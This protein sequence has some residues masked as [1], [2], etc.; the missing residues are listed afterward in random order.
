MN[1]IRLCR[2]ANCK[3]LP[4]SYWLQN[5]LQK[6]HMGEGMLAWENCTVEACLGVGGGGGVSQQQFLLPSCNLGPH[7][8]D[9]ASRFLLDTMLVFV[10]RGVLPARFG[11]LSSAVDS[12]QCRLL[13]ARRVDLGGPVA[14]VLLADLAKER[15]KKEKRKVLF[16]GGKTP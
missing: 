3:L 9:A 12:H 14:L 13:L 1:E 2:K 10:R 16:S 5:S 11:L 6:P 8:R 7:W 15:K 4:L